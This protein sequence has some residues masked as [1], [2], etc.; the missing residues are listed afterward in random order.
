MHLTRLLHTPHALAPNS[1]TEDP[2]SLL[3]GAE[4]NLFPGATP[5]RELLEQ[6][7]DDDD[8]VPG[9]EVD[10]IDRDLVEVAAL[11]RTLLHIDVR[12]TGG[13]GELHRPA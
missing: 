1:Q 3:A 7:P 2:P 12:L 9:L 6:S 10:G 13:K 5:L 8:L 11:M 4:T